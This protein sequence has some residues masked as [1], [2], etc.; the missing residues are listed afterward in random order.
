M[1]APQTIFDERTIYTITDEHGDGTT[2]TLD[3]L[4][5]DVLQDC[6]ADVHS[7]VQAAY[8]RV[9]QKLPHLTSHEGFA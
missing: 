8:D 6:L 1:T 5:A 2:I 4:T 3:K 9:T 7:R